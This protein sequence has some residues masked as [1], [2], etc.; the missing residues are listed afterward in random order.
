MRN[1]RLRG[2]LVT[3]DKNFRISRK[4][5]DRYESY[6]KRD[7]H[8]HDGFVVKQ[9]TCAKRSK[10]QAS[11]DKSEKK[12]NENSNHF[13]DLSADLNIP[14]MRYMT[15]KTERTRTNDR[16]KVF[17]DPD[18]ADSTLDPIPTYLSVKFPPGMPVWFNFDRVIDS[19]IAVLKAYEGTVI[20]VLRNRESG[21]FAYEVVRS[22]NA[23]K[24]STN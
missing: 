18:R 19:N 24:G 12:E 6:D 9:N 10:N 15:D 7:V 21:T 17:S 16:I 5:V 13:C 3:P 8:N 20:S 4:R 2:F 11:D 22:N 14:N 23:V 1:V